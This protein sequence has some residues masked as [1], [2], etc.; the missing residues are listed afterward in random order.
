[1]I[2]ASLY[3]F[4]LKNCSQGSRQLPPQL[5]CVFRPTQ[6]PFMTLYHF[7]IALCFLLHCLQRRCPP[8]PPPPPACLCPTHPGHACLAFPQNYENLGAIGE[9]TYGVVTKCRHKVTKE[10]VAIKKFKDN[11][12]D[13]QA[14]IMHHA[15]SLSATCS[16]CSGDGRRRHAARRRPNAHHIACAR[17]ACP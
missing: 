6:S 13:E 3:P 1:M 14:C 9:G 16:G 8:P 4:T 11:D 12:D 15:A 10:V 2:E 5:A 7:I 17:A